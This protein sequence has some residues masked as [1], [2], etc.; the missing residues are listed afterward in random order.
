MAHLGKFEVILCAA[1]V[2]LGGCAYVSQIVQSVLDSGEE[3][4]SANAHPTLDRLVGKGIVLSFIE[5][6]LTKDGIHRNVKVFSLTPLG[7]R[8]LKTEIYSFMTTAKR[9]SSIADVL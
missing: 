6:R 1:L 2:R 4:I 7:K 5:N 3:A 9:L 8:L